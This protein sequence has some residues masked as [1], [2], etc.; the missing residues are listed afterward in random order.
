MKAV[1]IAKNDILGGDGGLFIAGGMENMSLAPHLMKGMRGGIKMGHQQMLDSMISD[2]LWDPY[3]DVHMGN[4]AER[5]A[6][7]YS[8]SREAQDEYATM[9]FNRALESLQN[10]TFTEEIAPVTI[11]QRKGDPKVVSE[12]EGPT[13]VDISRISQLRPAFEKEGTV[14][15][16]NASTINDGAA[17]LLVAGE[18]AV[19]KH[20]LKPM[21]KIIAT[22]T[23][24]Q[25]PTWF[26]T[27]PVGAIQKALDKAGMTADQI[28]LY[29]INE[30]FSVVA[31]AAIKD[32][33]LDANKVNT[34]GGGLSLGHPIGASGARLL[35]T[36]MY[37]LKQ[38]GK[39][40]GLASLCIGGG[41]A[42]AI[43][44]E[45]LT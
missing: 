6:E 8:F 31:M 37:A 12:D 5:C 16:G 1:M 32:L 3:G 15:A 14:T 10:K 18:A 20:G 28:D 39:K 30:A 34:R 38:T 27:A 26:T 22:A 40:Y 19:A 2:G 42:T 9:S 21:A 17:A 7:K 45:N 11:P 29:E 25:D 36:L 35:V 41:E 23:H 43:I 4:C 44:I 13:K 33:G 24:S